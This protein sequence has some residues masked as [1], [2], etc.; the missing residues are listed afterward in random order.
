MASSLSNLVDNLSKVIHK[1]KCKY[2]NCF[3][4]YKRI[5]DDL[6]IYECLSCDEF[7]SRKLNKKLKRNLRFVIMTSIKLFCC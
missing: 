2:F 7:Y 6:I 5:E 4:E 3:L 1:I